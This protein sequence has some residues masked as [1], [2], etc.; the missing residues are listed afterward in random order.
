MDVEGMSRYGTGCSVQ[1][2]L[3]GRRGFGEPFVTSW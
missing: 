3:A 1:C 2:R